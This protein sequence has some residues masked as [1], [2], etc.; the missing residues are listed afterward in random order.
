MNRSD[1]A[2]RAAVATDRR[3][4]FPLGEVSTTRAAF[5]R[6]RALGLDPSDLIARHQA[7]DWGDI[8]D[9]DVA[10]NEESLHEK[11]RFFSSYEIEEERF[12]VL[13]TANRSSTTVFLPG[14]SA[15]DP[16]LANLSREG[17]RRRVTH[18]I[19]S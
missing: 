12:W 6:L 18:L 8:D 17:R 14:D 15:P 10:M 13:T 9:A 2:L 1:F 4:L 7:G 11:Q 3:A 5:D 19:Q 16:P